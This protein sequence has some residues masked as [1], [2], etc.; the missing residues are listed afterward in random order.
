MRAAAARA[1]ALGV[2][3]GESFA[4]V[5]VAVLWDNYPRREPLSVAVFALVALFVFV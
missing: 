3:R 4:L 2:V 1:L 5:G